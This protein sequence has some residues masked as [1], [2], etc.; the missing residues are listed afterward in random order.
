[1]SRPILTA[2]LLW[3]PLAILSPVRP[4]VVVGESMRPVLQ[5]G[6]LLLL[7]RDYYRSHTPERGDIIAFRWN[8]RVYIKRVHALAGETVPL[9]CQPGYCSPLLPGLES[10]ARRLEH[11]R[12]LF[13][14]RS[15]LVPAKHVYCLGDYHAASVDS[16]EMG[17]IPVSAIL[18]RV[19]P[20]WGSAAP[21]AS[22]V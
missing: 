2:S 9:L 15:D 20:L 4:L 19:Q 21:G 22:G 12:P 5:P 16:R 17:P 11:R 7:H 6:Q 13:H 8:D 18:G 3:I 10:K 14:V 1:M